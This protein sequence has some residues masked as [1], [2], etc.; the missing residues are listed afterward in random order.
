MKPTKCL[1]KEKNEAR[2]VKKEG[3]RESIKYLKILLSVHAQT[4]LANILFLDQKAAK[5]TTCKPLCGKFWLFIA[6]Q[7]PEDRL[8]SFKTHFLA[9]FPG[10]MGQMP[11]N[12]LVRDLWIFAFWAVTFGTFNYCQKSLAELEKNLIEFQL[13]CR[14]VGG[15]G[16]AALTFCLLRATSC[17][18]LVIVSL[19]NRTEEKRRHRQQ[20]LCDKCDNNFVSFLEYH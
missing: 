16:H 8:T 19:R 9:K 2:K 3:R 13:F 17:S 18:S 1:A 12:P 4:S 7:W 5:C 20:T 14:G 10:V 11:W 6:R 15:G